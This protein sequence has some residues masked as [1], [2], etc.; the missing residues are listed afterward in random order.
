MNSYKSLNDF[1]LLELI[2]SGDADAFAEIYERYWTLIL[3]HAL[4]MLKDDDE[5]K[6]LVQDVFV[7][8][9]IKIDQID[10]NTNIAGFLYISTR[11]K[12]LNLIR[13]N[14]IKTDYLSSLANFV[15]EPR[16]S[17]LEELS[18]KN[19]NFVIEK[20]IQNLPVKMREIFELSRKKFLSHKEIADVLDISDKTVKKQ[21][22]NAIRILKL[23]L[24]I[25][26]TLILLSSALPY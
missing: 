19:L 6:D 1:Q 16:N 23:R 18:A 17:A 2:K 13:H 12:I 8:L 20:E 22:N 15:S 25:L 5:A 21:I 3:H 10:P 11:N 9:W 4:K 26:P 14:Q 24:N 7:T